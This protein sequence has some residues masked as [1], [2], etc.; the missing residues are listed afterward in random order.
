MVPVPSNDGSNNDMNNQG[1]KF[2][3]KQRQSVLTHDLEL[4]EDET[5]ETELRV[6][7]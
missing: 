3:V 1:F 7:T 5:H 6:I 2:P 4:D